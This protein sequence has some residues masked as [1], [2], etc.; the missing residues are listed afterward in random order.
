MLEM[1][2]IVPALVQNFDMQLE[3]P[4][5]QMNTVNVM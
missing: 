1:L 2:K 5:A 3:E 4:D